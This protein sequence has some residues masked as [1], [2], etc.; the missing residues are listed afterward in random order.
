[1]RFKRIIFLL[2]VVS[3]STQTS[4]TES[5][6]KENVYEQAI[7]RQWMNKI[8]S[9]L[10]RN[11]PGGFDQPCGWMCRINVSGWM[12]TDAYITNTP[13]IFITEIPFDNLFDI[14]ETPIVLTSN[15]TS[16]LLL[17]NANL[18]ID[19]RVNP[20]MK[21]EIS[22]VYSSLSPF[23]GGE[24]KYQ[25]PNSLLI[26]K[27]INRI[28]LDTAYITLQNL[29]I[30]PLYLRWGKEYVPFG[31]YD[32]YSFVV[33]ENPTQLL[34]EINATTIQLGFT[35][36]NGLYGS[37]YTFA[38][39]PRLADGGV[40]RRI[41]NGGA[42]FGYTYSDCMSNFT[43]DG[44]YIGSITDTNFLSSY[45]TNTN[46]EV[47]FLIPGLPN[48]NQTTIPGLP[49]Q[50]APAYTVNAE[51]QWG[52]FDVN[53]H[54]IATT[55][56]FRKPLLLAFP[57]TPSPDQ[58]SVLTF[59]KPKLWGFELGLTFPAIANQTRLAVGYQAT[60]HLAGLLP[61]Q[62]IYVDYL[63]NIS[64]WFDIG[65]AI[66][67]NKDYALGEDQLSEITPTGR[68]LI[69]APGA[70]GNKSTV[71]QLRASIKFA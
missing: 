31:K 37:I 15:R 17:N 46:I 41:Q 11:Q 5:I 3:V 71:G 12:N 64:Q 36:P 6:V 53:G 55:R 45:Y 70:S 25:I 30:S 39:Q 26:Y 61:R 58:L 2:L 23:P 68:R 21:A 63:M 18:F 9:L 49:D 32:P 29:T 35:M 38:G 16:D 7:I 60:K 51:F 10:G 52:P 34:S 40:T 56:D 1:M 13:P 69:I 19:T 20:W 4:A 66:I 47:P 24:G 62:R 14:S 54:Y 8:D 57:V 44:G 22:L 42:N 27:P 33:S 28:N 65:V 67:Q 48:A 50:K 43:I 59:K